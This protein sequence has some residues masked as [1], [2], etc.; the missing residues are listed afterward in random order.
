MNI[1]TFERTVELTELYIAD[2]V[3][4]C[5]TSAFIAPV[6]EIDGRKIGNNRAGHEADTKNDS[7]T[8]KIQ[9]KY[10]ELFMQS[11]YLT[12]IKP[13]NYRKLK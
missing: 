11:I 13:S 5:G 10:K 8:A 1:P 3:F 2:E 6:I 9:E 12:K 4:A 7:L